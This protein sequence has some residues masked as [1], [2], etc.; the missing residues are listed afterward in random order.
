MKEGRAGPSIKGAFIRLSGP[1][2]FGEHTN[3]YTY[4]YKYKDIYIY[5]CKYIYRK[6][7]TNISAPKSYTKNNH[8]TSYRYPSKLTQLVYGY[9]YLYNNDRTSILVKKLSSFLADINDYRLLMVRKRSY[10]E[11]T[12]FPF[13]FSLNAI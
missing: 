5:I 12:I 3:I 4:I 1:R 10:A 9:I 8:Q 13:P 6:I 7:Y 11:K 2:D